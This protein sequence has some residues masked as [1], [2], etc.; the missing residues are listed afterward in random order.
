M[1]SEGENLREELAV[2]RGGNIDLRVPVEQIPCYETSDPE[3]LCRHPVVSVDMLAYNHEA[4][5]AQAIESVMMQETDFEYELIIGE[6][7]SSDRTR[8]ICFAYQ[9][10]YPDKIRVLWS[11]ENVTRPYGGNSARIQARCRGEFVAYCEGDDFWLDPKKLQKQVEIFRAHPTVNFCFT[12][13][14]LKCELQT[15]G[16]MSWWRKVKWDE[17][18]EASWNPGLHQPGFIPGSVFFEHRGCSPM[19][20]SVMVRRSFLQ[21]AHEQFDIF[22]WRLALGD[23]QLWIASA[24][25]GDAYFLKD[26]TGC[27]RIHGSGICSQAQDLIARDVRIVDAFFLAPWPDKQRETLRQLLV[28][29]LSEI[30]LKD[31]TAQQVEALLAMRVVQ[32][33]GLDKACIFRFY[34]WLRKW[35]VPIPFRRYYKLARHL[36]RPYRVYLAREEARGEK[37]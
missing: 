9:K 25:L 17:N 2:L 30:P 37:L 5:I 31:C 7:A 32:K 3:R 16:Q 20:N 8:E 35:R 23:R 19:T 12:G 22:R 1:L 28:L 18:R 4:F 33:V 11:E 10:R 13:T 14:R 24:L 29:R 15:G 21:Q 36:T 26:E 6:D 27:Y 34:R